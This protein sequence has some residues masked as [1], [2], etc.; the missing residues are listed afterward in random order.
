MTEN[1]APEAASRAIGE[2]KQIIRTGKLGGIRLYVADRVP[3]FTVP[4]WRDALKDVREVHFGK[5]PE[6]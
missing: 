4:R 5:P 2:G 3:W 1:C 6:A